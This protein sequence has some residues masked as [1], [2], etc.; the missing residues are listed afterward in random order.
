MYKIL[1]AEDSK[2]ILRDI[3]RQIK[4][5][6]YETL[7]ETSYDGDGALSILEKFEPD[8]IFTD[9]KMPF[10]DGLTLIHKAKIRY[11]GLKCIIISGYSDFSFTHEA[12]LLQVDDYIMKPVDQIQLQTLL[13]KLIEQIDKIHASKEERY[14]QSILQGVALT[15]HIS[16]VRKYIL[17]LVRVGLFQQY[18]APLDKETIYQI[19]GKS[20]CDRNIWIVSTK[21]NNEKIIVYNIEQKSEEDIKIQNTFLLEELSRQYLHVNI[22]YSTVFCCIEELSVQYEKLSGHLSRKIVFDHSGLY[23]DVPSSD[24]HIEHIKQKEEMDVFRKKMEHILKNKSEEDFHTE[25]KKRV[26]EWEYKRYTVRVIRGFIIVLLDEL[27]DSSIRNTQWLIEDPGALADK[28]LND[29]KNYED[30]EACLHSY[31]EF[32]ANSKGDKINVS[33]KIAQHIIEYMQ[34]NVYKNLNL[35]DIAERFEIS[36]SYICRLFKVYYNDTPIGYYNKLKIGEAKRLLSDY[37]DM[38][39]KDVADM[40]GFSDQYYFSKVFKQQ[41]GLNP[42]GFKNKCRNED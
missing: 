15:S 1:V 41:Y 2:L 8:I 24:E 31:G 26:Q 20:S 37:Q 10:I 13:A 22:I 9:I 28:I 34:T 32:V 21:L 6:G 4:A 33:I 23:E 16:L 42:I 40:L 35:Q 30:L 7:I 19:M 27:F 5:S 39:V 25:I 17:S 18:A 12:L 36:P 38:R 11:P 29:C 14:L 3:V